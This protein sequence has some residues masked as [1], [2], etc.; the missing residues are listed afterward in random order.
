MKSFIPTLVLSILA[1]GAAAQYAEPDTISISKKNSVG[2]Y[3]NPFAIA[4]MGNEVNDLR[5]GVQYKYI[6]ADNKRLRISAVYD[7]Q[8]LER[9]RRSL[10]PADIYRI[11]DSTEVTRDYGHERSRANMRLGYEWSDYTDPVD[12]FYAVDI[13]LGYSSEEYREGLATYLR[14]ATDS[15]GVLNGVDDELHA[16]ALPI[17]YNYHFLEMGLAPVFGWRFLMK[18][19]WE[20]QASISPEFYYAF[21][22]KE[23]WLGDSRQPLDYRASS[24]LEFRL[25]V[26][27]LVLSYHI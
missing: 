26:L 6:L 2:I 5:L 23:E 8:D 7:R 22:V 27:E 15:T 9:P 12:A 21:P 1:S 4:F 3:I 19:Q 18:Q 10:D 25:R 16:H 20:L 24:T 17:A 14:E 11:T 13:V